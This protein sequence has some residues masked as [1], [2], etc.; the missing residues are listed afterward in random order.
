MSEQA[1]TLDIPEA[2]DFLLT[3][4]RYKSAYGGRGAARSW[5]YARAL[6]TLASYQ[7]KRILCTR[8]YQNS[9]KDSV[10]KVLSDQIDMLG[11][12]P[13]YTVNNNGIYSR[14]G[15]EFIFK[16]LQHPL[17]IKSLEGID[18]AW[19][20]EA[21]N[22]SNNSWEVLIPT[23]RKDNSEIWLSWN[24]GEVDDPTY[25]RFVVNKPDDCI[26]KLMTWRDNPWFPEVLEKERRYLLRVDPEAYDHVWEGTPKQ[27]S[28]AQIFKGKFVIEAF[29]TPN[30]ASFNYGADWGFSNDPA[31]LVRNFIVGRTLFIDQEAWAIGVELDDFDAFYSGGKSQDGRRTFEGIPEAK[32]H[33][34][35]A[36]DSRPETISYVGRK[37]YIIEAAPKGKGS[38]E[39]GIAFMRKFEKIVIHPRCKH[40]AQEFRSY[41]YKVDKKTEEVLTDIIDADNHTIDAHRYSL[42]RHIRGRFSFA[43]EVGM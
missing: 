43:E 15:S 11:L 27:H 12:Q 38:V 22:V 33:K 1:I 19:A 32:R 30:D 24:T 7:K 28:D 18:I 34:I 35:W 42:C 5:S 39:D 4:M 6:V 2:F 29:E 37:G 10:H 20:E 8:E 17:E 41:S 40:T 23:V 13:Y 31:T 25:Q 21:Q 9:I 16:G 26:S 14:C 36:D 3:P